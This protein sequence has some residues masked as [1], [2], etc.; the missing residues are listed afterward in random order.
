MAHAAGPVDYG[1]T[2]FQATLGYQFT[3]AIELTGGWQWYD[4]ARNTG[5]FTN[6]RP[7][8]R[9]NAG[10]IGLSYIL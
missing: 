8:I 9:M 2:G 4:Y 7:A 10:Y 5:L 1:I 6:S 3:P